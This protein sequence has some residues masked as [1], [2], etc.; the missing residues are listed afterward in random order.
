MQR[1]QDNHNKPSSLQV[2]IHSMSTNKQ[3]LFFL[4]LSYRSDRS[5]IPMTARRHQQSGRCVEISIC[6]VRQ[7]APLL[8]GMCERNQTSHRLMPRSFF[9]IRKWR[10]INSNDG[11]VILILLFTKWQRSWLH[12]VQAEPVLFG[13]EENDC[14]NLCRKKWRLYIYSFSRHYVSINYPSQDHD[15]QMA[16]SGGNC[17]NNWS[18]RLQVPFPCAHH[19][20]HTRTRRVIY[21]WRTRPTAR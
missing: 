19:F 4:F 5:A 11:S 2:F 15:G 16:L 13:E 10:K 21:R 9:S 1:G 17:H 14:G 20:L 8:K 18:I 12:C 6:R 3:I 7:P